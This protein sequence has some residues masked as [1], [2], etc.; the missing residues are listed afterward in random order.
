MILLNNMDTLTRAS[1]PHLAMMIQIMRCISS[2]PT[3][4]MMEPEVEAEVEGGEMGI[5]V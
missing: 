1:K 2:L 4:E 3:T 5:E